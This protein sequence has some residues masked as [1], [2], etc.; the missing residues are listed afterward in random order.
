LYKAVAGIIFNIGQGIWVARVGEQ[1]EVGDL[2]PS[3]FQQQTD[4]VTADKTGSAGYYESLHFW[5]RSKRY[6]VIEAIIR[7]RRWSASIV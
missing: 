2:A 3:L 7:W 6:I 5:Q 4:K 1:I